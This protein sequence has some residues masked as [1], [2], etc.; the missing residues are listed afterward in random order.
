[1]DAKKKEEEKLNVCVTSSISNRIIY[2]LNLSHIST[3]N[4]TSGQTNVYAGLLFSYWDNEQTTNQIIF[5]FKCVKNETSNPRI[6]V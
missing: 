2:T 4:V 5:V 1:M 6:T 3:M